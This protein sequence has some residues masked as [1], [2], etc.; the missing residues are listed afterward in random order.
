MTT[1]LD[2]K[3]KKIAKIVKKALDK[4]SRPH[5]TS[6]Q[7]YKYQLKKGCLSVPEFLSRVTWVSVGGGGWGTAVEILH[8]EMDYRFWRIALMVTKKILD[9]PQALKIESI[10]D[11]AKRERE[12]QEL[13]TEDQKKANLQVIIRPVVQ[14]TLKEIQEITGLGDLREA[15]V[16]KMLEAFAG[17]R[18]R[19]TQFEGLRLRT[20]DRV[21]WERFTAESGDIASVVH[22]RTTDKEKRGSGAGKKQA[23]F[24]LAFYSRIGLSFYHSL[25][26]GGHTL[27]REAV[28]LLREPDGYQ[29]LILNLCTT[30]QDAKI[31]RDKLL[32]L[33]GM[34]K[35]EDPDSYR[36]QLSKLRGYIRK[37]IDDRYFI[38]FSELDGGTWVIKK[39][40]APVVSK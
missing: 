28:K 9:N 29:R 2:A 32:A 34:A 30:S 3:R 21:G 19:V 7:K 4:D 23:L 25:C 1:D 27:L 37:G 22:E 39:Q 10:E 15:E 20:G 17:V 26:T 16:A 38:S 24:T 12:L 11:L 36:H 6:D 31:H 33:V 18:L 35:S 14:F 13:L 5:L 8:G 40:W